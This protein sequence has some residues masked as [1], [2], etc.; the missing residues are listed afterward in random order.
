MALQQQEIHANP[1]PWEGRSHDQLKEIINRGLA[2][3]DDFIL[4]AR[5]MERRSREFE[6]AEDYTR[7]EAARLSHSRR[8]KIGLAIWLAAIVSVVAWLLLG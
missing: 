5:E 6:D 1:V 2:G 4:A 8:L 7:A 3:G